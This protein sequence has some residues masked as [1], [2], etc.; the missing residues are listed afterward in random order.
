M[1]GC[2]P[3]FGSSNK[4]ASSGVGAVK[5]LNKNDS[6]KEGS[7]GQSHHVGRVSSDK[8]KSKS[9]SGSDPKKE[10]SIPKDGPTASIAAQTFTFRELAAA[11][12]N[13]RPECLLGEGGFG[14]VYKGRIESIG[15]VVAVKQLDRN[16]LQGNREFLVE[17]LM[18][19]LLHH[20]NLVNLIGYCAD[21]DQRLLVYEFMPL[22]SLE[23]HLHG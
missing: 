16:G 4:E 21:G 13:F 18:L 6:L 12:K 7:A 11:T 22:G 1:G 9:L 8:S 15:Q 17:V 23:D 10:Q 3:C 19:S 2:F 20:P 5:E 14:R